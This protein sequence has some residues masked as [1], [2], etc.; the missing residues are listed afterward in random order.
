[1]TS[2]NR[3]RTRVMSSQKRVAW[4]AGAGTPVLMNFIP[5]GQSNLP[6]SNI[7]SLC[8]FSQ[9]CIRE[10]SECDF[11]ESSGKFTAKFHNTSSLGIL[12]E[13]IS[14]FLDRATPLEYLPLCSNPSPTE[15][16]EG[17]CMTHHVTQIVTELEK[18]WRPS[19]GFRNMQPS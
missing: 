6:H 2:S 3:A 14:T 12:L 5:N 9:N 7:Y 8:Y 10:G 13:Q 1:M 19:H 17:L 15:S 4:P 18:E 11:L 16:V